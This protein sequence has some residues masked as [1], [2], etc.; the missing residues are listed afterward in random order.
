MALA[1]EVSLLSG[2]TV[3]LEAESR[4]LVETA[5]EHRRPCFQLRMS[6]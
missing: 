3:S 6:L 1:I 5:L 4:E 2:R